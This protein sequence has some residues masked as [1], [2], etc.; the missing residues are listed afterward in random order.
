MTIR[1]YPQQYSSK[2]QLREGTP[3]T[4]RAIRPED[5]PLMVK[6]HGTLSEE[7]VHFR[8]FGFS[9]LELR[10]FDSEVTTAI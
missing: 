9:K 3:I 1:P 10:V 5:E 4:I 8:Y 6:F 2:C 7:T